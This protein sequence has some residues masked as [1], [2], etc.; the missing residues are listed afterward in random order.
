VLVG[1]SVLLRCCEGSSFFKS[2][3]DLGEIFCLGRFSWSYLLDMIDLWV[4]GCWWSMVI[5]MVEVLTYAR[6]TEFL[7]V[8]ELSSCA[9]TYVG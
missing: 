1:L 2:V 8:F 9:R 3:V 7:I 6:V 4:V 5:S